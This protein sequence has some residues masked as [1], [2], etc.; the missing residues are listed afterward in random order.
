MTAGSA[1][2]IISAPRDRGDSFGGLHGFRI[3]ELDF[4]RP[5]SAGNMYPVIV[6]RTLQRLSRVHGA[7]QLLLLLA[8]VFSSLAG[9][10]DL[11]PLPLSVLLCHLLLVMSQFRH[12][13]KVV[14]SVLD[15]AQDAFV[16]LLP[17]SLV[18]PQFY[19]SS[20]C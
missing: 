13:D 20:D 9:L 10:L 17:V 19:G 3:A 16:L 4:R 14:L 2:L 6:S 8:I 5:D 11:Q 1:D 18:S 12:V 7:I 15:R